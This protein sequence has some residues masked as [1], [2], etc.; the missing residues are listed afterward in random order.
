MSA[1]GFQK[2]IKN[3]NRFLK[4][5]VQLEV[6]AERHFFKGEETEVPVK[7]PHHVAAEGSTTSCHSKE[8][9]A[10]GGGIHVCGRTTVG[11]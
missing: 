3:I 4:E 8:V 5:V 7:T 6:W 11:C 9:R 2:Q 1:I 10:E